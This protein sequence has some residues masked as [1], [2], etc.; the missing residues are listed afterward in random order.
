[1]AVSHLNLLHSPLEKDVETI[2]HPDVLPF[3]LNESMV[4]I[5]PGS[6]CQVV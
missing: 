3:C 1:M 6:G 4:L 5:L 2:P